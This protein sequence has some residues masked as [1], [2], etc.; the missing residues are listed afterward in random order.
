[1]TG[2]CGWLGDP[3]GVAEAASALR[4][5]QGDRVGNGAK[6]PVTLCEAPDCGLW[7]SAGTDSATAADGQLLA[8]VDGDGKF[9]ARALLDEYQ[10]RGSVDLARLR[11]AFSFVLLD[12][13]R[14]RALLAV[15]R[16]G[17][18]PLCHAAFADGLVFGGSAAAVA[19]HPRI[20]R[21]L[22]PQ[23]IHDFAFL[24]TCPAPRTI[25]AGVSKLQPAERLEFS[26]G[27]G[28]VGSY[29]APPFVNDVRAGAEALG[30]G[31]RETLGAAVHRAAGDSRFGTF[32]SGGLDSS[33]VTG[34]AARLQP[35]ME[36]AYTIGFE[37]PDYDESHFARVAAK[38]FGVDLRLYF[39]TPQ[40]VADSL[41]AITRAYDEPFGNSSAVP[42]FICAS[43]AAADGLP[44]MLAGDGG[45]ELFAG[46]ERYAKQSLFKYY[47]MLPGFLRSGV[48][49][50]L[51]DGPGKRSSGGPLRKLYRYVD[52]ARAGTGRRMIE[53]FDQRKG[54]AP[55][56]L[57]SAEFFRQIDPAR[58]G[59]DL[60]EFFERSPARSDL[61][62]MLHL[63]WKITLADN[64]LRKVNR[65]CELAG[66][67]VRYPMLD[68]EVV[69]LSMRVPDRLKLRGHKL[70]YFYKQAFGNFLPQEVINKR[71][72][73][74]GLPFGEWL[75]TEPVLR[76][77]TY[78]ALES[79]KRRGIFD[80]AAIDRVVTMHRE[81]HASYY[82][83]MVWALL[84]LELWF[85]EHPPLL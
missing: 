49:D 38:H 18:R 8:A 48:L 28:T 6:P 4:A 60:V 61:D 66:I 53:V 31:L 9:T 11:G 25:Y 33:T 43:K 17:I 55:D 65:M 34:L 68:E 83:S 41:R 50:P 72:H 85:E 21:R 12:R 16:M 79:L 40:D 42:T 52:Q 35:R 2:Y 78:P 58:P 56:Q 23:A 71:K 64:D 70:R 26:S 82:G 5:A 81:G 59:E 27:H 24:H 30:A 75:K 1:M 39:V 32:L 63:D 44:L 22:N 77:T 20:G 74:F 57:F 19:A 29:W 37:H 47:G 13:T 36:H 80:P 15:D 69:D 62:R 7:V 76:D 51:A 14:R 10:S 73:G 67:A 84:M 3:G 46:N 45:D 54:I